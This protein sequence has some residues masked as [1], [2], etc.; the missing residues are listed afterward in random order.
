MGNS[1]LE[2]TYIFL[3]S[4]WDHYSF[5]TFIVGIIVLLGVWFSGALPVITRI[6]FGLARR[7]IALFAKGE[8]RLSL[9]KLIVDSALF[10]ERNLIEIGQRADF[11]SA[12][13]AS[14]YVI[15]WGDWTEHFPDIIGLAAGSIPVIVFAPP[16]SGDIKEEEME[17]IHNSPNSSVV[18][19]RGRLLNDLV[20]SIITTQP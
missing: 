20:T 2:E 17:L 15:A 7:K 3:K 14:V 16:G 1:C 19:F 12:K 13:K 10:R 18:R 11:G 8:N 5:L 9:S 4:L 6:G